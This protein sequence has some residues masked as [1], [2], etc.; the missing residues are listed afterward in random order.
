MN[1]ICQ[2]ARQS[3]VQIDVDAFN[4][5]GAFDAFDVHVH[6]HV[7]LCEGRP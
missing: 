7:L 2:K 1:D 4:A 6:V 5:F 3:I